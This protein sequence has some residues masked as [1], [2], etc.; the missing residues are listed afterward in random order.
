M[1]GREEL[2]MINYQQLN[3]ENHQIV[4]LSKILSY[5]FQDRS[6]CDTDT[7]C[8]L[9]YRYIDKVNQHMELVDNNLYKDLLAHPENDI[10]NV[11][12]NFMSGGQEIKHILN[13]YEKKWCRKMKQQILVGPKHEQFLKET[14]EMFALILDR[15]QRETERLY[16]LVREITGDS[17][18]AA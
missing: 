18:H 17:R 9:F 10:K 4:E 1:P 7:C 16:P 12:R 13:R 15:I 3:E 11:A 14:E 2:E 6:M 8:S 5:L